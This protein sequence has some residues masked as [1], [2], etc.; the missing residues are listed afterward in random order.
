MID[1]PSPASRPGARWWI[2]LILGGVFAFLVVLTLAVPEWIEE[3]FGVDPDGGD[4]SLE[5]K[6]ALAFGLGAMGSLLLAG[7]EL[8][9]MQWRRTP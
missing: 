7:R 2:E 4:G 8:R 9:R 6:L 5:W 3:V 1:E